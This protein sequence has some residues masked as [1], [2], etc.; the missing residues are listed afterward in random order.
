MAPTEILAE[1]HMASLSQLLTPLGIR[2]ELLTGSQTAKQKR[3]TREAIASGQAQLIVGTHAVVSE[4]TV[5][6]DLG[7]VITDEQHRFGVGQRSALA[8]KGQDPHLLVMSATPIP[9]TL[10]LLMYG[11]LEVS[12]LDE[13]P[14]GREPV[15]TYLV[16]ESYRARINAFIRKQVEQGHQCYVV[17]PAVEENEALNLKAAETWAQTLQQ[18]VFPD[19]KVL[20]LHGQMKGAEKEAVMADFASGA[21]DVLVATTVIEVGVDVPNATL[22]VIEDADRFGLSQLHQ[23]R[24]RVGRGKAKSHCILISHNKNAETVQRL[25]ALCATTD[26]FQIAEEDLR[27]RGPGDFFGVRQ[28]GLPV[29]RVANLSCDLQTLKQAQQASVQWIDREGTAET[30]EAEALRSR[31]GQLFARSEGTMN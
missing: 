19:L 5:F 15:G 30:P 26:G 31:I 13:L 17:C 24:G 7:L 12:I 22:M 8:G 4:T 11:D 6:H 16:N 20:L 1:Q 9:R 14:P 25:K 21:G 28:S 3:L 23:L 29:F 2:V 18:A 27:L 10:A